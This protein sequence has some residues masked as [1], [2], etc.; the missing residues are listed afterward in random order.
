MSSTYA[1]AIFDTWSEADTSPPT[2]RRRPWIA[3]MFASA[4][5]ARISSTTP[6][7]TSPT[8]KIAGGLNGV[9]R[10]T[11]CSPSSSS[12]PG[13]AANTLPS[14]SYVPSPASYSSVTATSSPGRT[15]RDAIVRP[16]DAACRI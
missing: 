6:Y 4:I 10:A 8:R 9:T 7:T 15:T 1:F 3:W 16:R 12:L 5:E 11:R 2:W 13:C 14:S